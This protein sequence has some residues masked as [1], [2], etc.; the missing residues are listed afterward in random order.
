MMERKIKLIPTYFFAAFS[1]NQ[2][3]YHSNLLF[4]R[5]L[6]FISFDFSTFR[7]PFF[8]FTYGFG[9]YYIFTS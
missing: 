4:I 9:F 1:N 2:Y 6:G 8:S 7:L 5:L 3:G